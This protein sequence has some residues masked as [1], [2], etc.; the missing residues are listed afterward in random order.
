MNSKTRSALSEQYKNSTLQWQTFE[1][2]FGKNPPPFCQEELS[3]I[4]FLFF[5]ALAY[6]TYTAFQLL[7]VT[8]IHIT[9]SSS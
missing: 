8:K 2:L 5:L 6:S 4:Y 7:Q 9:Q 1:I 3:C